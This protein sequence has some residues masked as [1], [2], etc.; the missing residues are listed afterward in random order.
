MKEF[1]SLEDVERVEL[2]EE[3]AGVVRGVLANVEAFSSQIA[4]QARNDVEAILIEAGDTDDAIRAVLGGHT[5]LDATLEGCVRVGTCFLTCV[6]FN[7]E[8]GIS[9]VVHDAPWLDPAVR[10]RL[11][12]NL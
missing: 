10:A 4:S 1:R 5:L 9:I 11:E 8:Y 7:N 12:D 6:L 3:V 2:P